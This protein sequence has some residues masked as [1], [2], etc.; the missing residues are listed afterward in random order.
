[1]VSFCSDTQQEKIVPALNEKGFSSCNLEYETDQSYLMKGYLHVL[2]IL[3]ALSIFLIFS[4]L[5]SIYAIIL[6]SYFTLFD[7]NRLAY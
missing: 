5:Y 7:M 1:M 6:C 4:T 2:M 3:Y